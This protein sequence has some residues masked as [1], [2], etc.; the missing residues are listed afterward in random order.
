MHLLQSDVDLDAFY[1][2]IDTAA[3]RVLMLDYD[4]TLAPFVIERDKAVPYPGVR[5]ILAA[6]LAGERTRLVVVSGR[7]IR[8]L[9][10]LLQIEP[11]P[12]IWGS[13]GWERRLPDGTYHEPIFDGQATKGLERARA[14]VTHAGLAGHCEDKPVSIAFH[15]RGLDLERIAFLNHEVSV[16]WSHIAEEAG[17]EL[18]SFDGGLE[19]YVP[20]CNKG[21]AVRA[22][23]HEQGDVVT[24]YLGDDRTDEDAFAA[25]AE[26]GLS[27]LVREEFRPTGA[28]LW[29]VPPDELLSFLEKW[30]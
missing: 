24:A 18:K 4:G 29:I 17:L 23:L 10:P 7:S 12:E 20:G 9:E 27:V 21:D 28:M 3:R 8:D 15:W 26:Y 14:W 22:I 25:V 13:H 19:L 1:Q 2:R 30:I 6:I 5:E 16:H 11:L